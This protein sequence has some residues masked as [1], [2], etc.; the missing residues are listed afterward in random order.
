M[1]CEEARRHAGLAP[2]ALDDAGLSG[3]LEEKVRVNVQADALLAAGRAVSGGGQSG[4]TGLADPVRALARLH[5]GTVK[6]FKKGRMANGAVR[7]GFGRHL[8]RGGWGGRN[9]T[10][11]NKNP[12]K[13][14]TWSKTAVR[15]RSNNDAGNILV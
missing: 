14:V 12:I 2:F 8:L 10:T 4:R 3:D 5:H 11:L 9:R 1:P 7:A 6:Y 13:G 15:K